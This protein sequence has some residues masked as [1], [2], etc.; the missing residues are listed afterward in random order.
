MSHKLINSNYTGFTAADADT[1]ATVD[2]NYMFVGQEK[3]TTLMVGNTNVNYCTFKIV[4]SGENSPLVDAVE[5][6]LDGINWASDVKTDVVSPNGVSQLIH[7][8]FTVPDNS[9][10]ASGTFVI[11]VDEEIV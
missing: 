11:H 3:K 10:T 7:C 1:L 8:K 4:A 2:F 9:F 5:F 6:S